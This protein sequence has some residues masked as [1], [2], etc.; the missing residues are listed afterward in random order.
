M[1]RHRNRWH[2][3][4][5][6]SHCKSSRCCSCVL[7]GSV[8]QAFWTMLADRGVY[9]LECCLDAKIKGMTSQCG[10]IGLISRQ[11]YRRVR[12][13]LMLCQYCR[14]IRYRYRC[15]TDTGTNCGTYVHTGTGCGTYVHAGTAG[16]GI[17]VVPNLLKCP[18]PVLRSYRA[19]RSVRYR[20]E[21]LYRHRQYRY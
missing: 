3:C 16:I 11:T 18:V 13:G 2:H 20:Y 8:Y 15:C 5:R 1:T 12:Y 4:W 9:G 10:G 21:S 7:R 14:S 19:Y 6:P 17:D